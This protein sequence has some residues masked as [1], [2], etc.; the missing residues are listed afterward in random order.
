MSYSLCRVS[1]WD[2]CT[3]ARYATPSGSEY[4]DSES[5]ADT[6]L[7]FWIPRSVLVTSLLLATASAH[8]GR[9]G[10][11]PCP[12]ASA[13]SPFQPARHERALAE[14]TGDG[15]VP[16]GGFTAV[17]DDLEALLTD[18]K[19]FWPADFGNYGGLFIRLAWHCR[20]VARV[21]AHGSCYAWYIS[22]AYAQA[23][24]VIRSTL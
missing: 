10:S 17:M 13:S 2:L 7:R 23:H 24:A 21:L 19:D 20:Y 18:S 9:S 22:P 14:R 12:Y 6:V 11:E 4:L 1:L 5:F 3:Y 15:G 16:E 8:P